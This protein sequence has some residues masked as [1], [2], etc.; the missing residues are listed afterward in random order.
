MTKYYWRCGYV[1]TMSMYGMEVMQSWTDGRLAAVTHDMADLRLYGADVDALWTPALHVVNA[2]RRVDTA[3][4]SH[5]V[6]AVSTAGLVILHQRCAST[7]SPL[8]IPNHLLQLPKYTI[9]HVSI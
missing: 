4:D 2:R 9:N 6:L 8:R 7:S 5:R 3:P 1:Q